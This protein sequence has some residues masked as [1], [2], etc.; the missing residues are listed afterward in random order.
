MNSP[1][2]I[3]L[4]GALYALALILAF[5]AGACPGPHPPT[6]P[7]VKVEVCSVSGILPNPY[8]PTTEIREFK[9][10]AVPV[11]TCTV[12]HA[13]DPP[14][15]TKV[16]DP[17]PD[18]SGELRAWSG[19]LYSSLC[20]AAGVI[21][22][23]KLENL[24]EALALDGINA[25]RNFAW[26]ADQ[27][28]AWAGQYLLP[29][30]PDWSWNEAYWAQLNRRLQLWAGDRNGAEIISILDA[31]SLYSGD[32]WDVNP[33]NKLVTTPSQVFSAGPARDKI[34]AFA[35]ELARRTAKFAPRIIY[36][37]RNEGGQIVGFDALHDYDTAIIAALKAE[38]VPSLNIQVNWY[39]SSLFYQTISEALGG[40]GLAAT[41][42][43]CSEVDADW[44][45]DSPGKQGL[46]DAGD[47]PCSDGPSFGVGED[48]PAYRAKGMTFHWLM[49]T[50]AENPGRRP[51]PGQI[52][53]IFGVMRGIKH[54]RFEQL[55]AVAFQLTNAPDL[56]AAVTLG[57]A[58]RLALR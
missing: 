23:A 17:W 5:T 31:C 33:L 38:G 55:S 8:C 7:L 40:A 9:P 13:P 4:T 48:P 12:H 1:H 29:W 49:G 25:E 57:R 28:D 56:D 39:D 32:S 44:Y 14:A 45:R 51:D 20:G 52:C 26:F 41:H 6:P 19:T 3:R 11:L 46:A 18:G 24:Y 43:I 22:E 2:R 42:Q 37:T 34:A 30:A 36:E 50:P 47:Y 15:K 35:R 10:D 16:A 27:S 54:P 58:E 53:Y 21:D